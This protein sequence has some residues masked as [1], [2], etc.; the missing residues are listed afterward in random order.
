MKFIKLIT[1]IGF[2][3]IYVLTIKGAWGNPKPN[4][5]KNVLDQPT[6]AFELSPERGRYAQVIS[7]VDNHSYALSKTLADAVYPDV[8][9]YQGRFYAYFAP[10]ISLLAAPFY[11]LGSK[12]NLAQVTTFSMSTLF[13]LATEICIYIISRKIIKISDSASLFAVLIYAFGSFSWSYATT[14]Y[15]HHVTAFLILSGFIAAWNFKQPNSNKLLYAL[16]VG[17]SFGIGLII[18]YPNGLFM[19]PIIGYLIYNSITRLHA[20]GYLKISF[21]PIILFAFISFMGITAYHLYYNEINFGSWKRVSGSLV[22]YKSILIHNLNPTENN[23]PAI[24]ALAAKKNPVQFFSETQFPFGIYTLAVSRDRGILLYSPVFILALFGFLIL[25]KNPNPE[26]FTLSAIL[27]CIIFL[28][29]SFHD[30]WG[31]WAFGPRYLIPA[32]PIFAI[33]SGVTL[34]YYRSTWVKITAFLLYLYSGFV[35]LVGVIT[36]NAI[37]PKVEAD[38]LHIGYNFMYNLKF[39]ESNRSS[40]FIYKSFLSPRFTLTQYFLILYLMVVLMGFLIIFVAP[41]KEHL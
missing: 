1:V 6:Q 37:P 22:G 29:A 23:S 32:L 35:S 20:N 9:Y 8:G 2:I 19:L 40:S 15:Q 38:F 21:Q 28:Y 7:L 41:R 10:G 33:Y 34:S 17:L 13:A 5:I 26:I 39:L 30:P 3:L 36:T 24:S 12:I 27:V 16:Y 18:D 25:I 14:L 4:E 11:M 31:G